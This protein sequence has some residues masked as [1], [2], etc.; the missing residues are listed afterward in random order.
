M[1]E[2]NYRY[3]TLWHNSVLLLFLGTGSVL[4]TKGEVEMDSGRPRATVRVR[5]MCT[6]HQEPGVSRQG[7]LRKS[8]TSTFYTKPE[9]IWFDLYLFK[10]RIKKKILFGSWK[11]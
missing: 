6:K 9:Y 1:T 3:L 5:G 10:L 4:N 2:A 7:R 11:K 8:E